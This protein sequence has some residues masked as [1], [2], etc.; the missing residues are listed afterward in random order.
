MPDCGIRFNKG[1]SL[2]Y[3]I[4]FEKSIS[5]HVECTLKENTIRHVKNE[6]KGAKGAKGIKIDLN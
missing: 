1:N 6:G 5:L 4:I 3:R 2:L